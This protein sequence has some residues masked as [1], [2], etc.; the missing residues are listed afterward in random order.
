MK[1]KTQRSFRKRFIK[2]SLVLIVVPALFIAGSY[3]WFVR[4]SK[5]LLIDLVNER[6]HG[7]LSLQLAEVT[8]NFTN[9]TVKIR[10]AKITSTTKNVAPISYQVKPYPF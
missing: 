6:S 1:T 10:E 9:S 2:V 7:R 4:N 5:R 8:F 3:V